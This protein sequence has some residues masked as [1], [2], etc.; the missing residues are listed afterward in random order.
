MEFEL[1]SQIL[2]FEDLTKLKLEKIDDLFAKATNAEGEHPSFVLVNPYMLR[3][4][5]FELPEYIK[6]LLGITE[7]T[8]NIAVYNT[9][10]VQ[11][12]LEDSLINFL[13]PFV[14]NFDT[15]SVAQVV[16]DNT[17]YPQYGILEPFNKFTQ[18]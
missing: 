12:P 2:G 3:E 11:T 14:F 1:K 13:A 5:D 8:E 6:V 10:V 15:Q 7:D 4:Y 18:Q 9:M 17:T 16:L